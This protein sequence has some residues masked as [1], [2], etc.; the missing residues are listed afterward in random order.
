MRQLSAPTERVGQAS[1]WRSEKAFRQVIGAHKLLS[2]PLAQMAE[3][4]SKALQLECASVCLRPSIGSLPSGE[5]VPQLPTLFLP[6]YPKSSST[7]LFS[8]MS[9]AFAPELL[10]GLDWHDSTHSCH[11]RYMLRPLIR[12]GPETCGDPKELFFFNHA[13]PTS[14]LHGPTLP[15]RYFGEAR[16]PQCPR[17]CE[18]MCEEAHA[19]ALMNAACS[20]PNHTEAAAPGCKVVHPDSNMFRSLRTRFGRTSVT[21]YFSS[22]LPRASAAAHGESLPFAVAD[23]TPDYLSDHSAM[24]RIWHTA[25]RVASRSLDAPMRSPLACTSSARREPPT[26]C[27]LPLAAH[28]HYPHAAANT[29]PQLDPAGDGQS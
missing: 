25:R 16:W 26:A 7:W 20:S 17:S 6:G 5:A 19:V 22:A 29:A 9:A 10:C 3:A 2:E 15:L 28:F 12:C 11:S 23:A 14:D 4:F 24:E 21:R 18:D 27:A 13:A 1:A 8:C